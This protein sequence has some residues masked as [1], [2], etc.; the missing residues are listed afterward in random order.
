MKKRIFALFLSLVL[1]FT[2][3][4]ADYMEAYATGMEEAAAASVV[5]SGIEGG[6]A[7]AIGPEIAIIAILAALGITFIEYKNNP[8]MQARVHNTI[9]HLKS[10]CAKYFD[11]AG[12]I[13]AWK[14]NGTTRMAKELIEEVRDYWSSQWD[15]WT[16]SSVGE[17]G[18]YGNG[19]TGVP[20]MVD[21]V[22]Q[23]T[24]SVFGSDGSMIGTVRAYDG[25]VAL[26]VDNNLNLD[27]YGLKAYMK[28]SNVAYGE[29]SD[30]FY[31]IS[32]NDYR[33]NISSDGGISLSN[34][35]NVP[36]FESTA[37]MRDYLLNGTEDGILNKASVDT[38]INND[39]LAVDEQVANPGATD[40]FEEIYEKWLED[41]QSLAIDD[42]INYPNTAADEDTIAGDIIDSLPVT[43][44]GTIDDVWDPTMDDAQ[45]GVTDDDVV[46][47]AADEAEDV[48]TGGIID[49][50][51]DDTTDLIGDIIDWGKDYI[52]PTTGILSKFPF[53]ILYDM[54][55][56]LAAFSG[57]GG[58]PIKTDPDNVAVVGL[59]APSSSY[60]VIQTSA[61][62]WDLNFQ[63]PILGT[64]VDMPI[65]LDLSQFGW[66]FKIIRFGVGILWLMGLLGW[67]KEDYE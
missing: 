55:L 42:A 19:Y 14:V 54:Y 61:L 23:Y 9:V 11:K 27:S 57:G 1:I 59:E 67:R 12:N 4:S 64:P 40:T 63:I 32:R 46:G 52:S 47:E 30:F 10:T 29:C 38:T 41:Q 22:Y 35:F 65:N 37:A 66:F 25:I 16:T 53:S 18:E 17:V 2:A 3:A 39:G 20:E 49:D 15:A 44:P 34:D 33:P 7:L 43:L 51:I 48:V 58:N 60:S 50:G 56:I 62:H 36:I 45:S 6:V 13:V 31:R 8:A 24:G 28:V 21:G 5:V 26:E